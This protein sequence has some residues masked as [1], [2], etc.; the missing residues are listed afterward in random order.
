MTDKVADALEQQ[1]DA[2]LAQGKKIF[3]GQEISAF[4]R[5]Q[6]NAVRAY[7]ATL[8]KEPSREGA[9]RTDAEAVAAEYFRESRYADCKE[10]RDIFY[11]GLAAAQS[12][13]A[14][15]RARVAELE[16]QGYYIVGWLGAAD[17]FYHLPEQAKKDP[18]AYPVYK[19]KVK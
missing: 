7:S 11:A 15:L 12:E 14:A 4:L 16:K 6:A 10:H 18:S 19:R 8:H 2:F 5:N 1:A 9:P 13:A 3:N 17:E